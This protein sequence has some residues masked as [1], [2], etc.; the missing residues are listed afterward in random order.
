[1]NGTVANQNDWNALDTNDLA[2]NKTELVSLNQAAKA[3][4]SIYRIDSLSVRILLAKEI[5]Q[6]LK[7]NLI[8]RGV[9]WGVQTIDNNY[10]K[11]RLLSFEK[12]GDCVDLKILLKTAKELYVLQEE[13]LD[14]L[15]LL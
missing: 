8:Q 2:E 7:S 14:L 5:P 9:K 3:E 6:Q 12:C 1:M 4:E 11:V 15:T 10:Y 13:V